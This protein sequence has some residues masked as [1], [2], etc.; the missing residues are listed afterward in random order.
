MVT[1]PGAE[2]YVDGEALGAADPEGRAGPFAVPAG[3]RVIRV[4][5]G[6]TRFERQQALEVDAD[7]RHETE[8]RARRGF[9]RLRVAPWARVRVNGKPMG[10]TPLPPISLFE[11]LHEIEL[12]NPVLGVRKTVSARVL[13][14]EEQLV[15]VVLARGS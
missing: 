6:E 5:H 11:G 4:V 15:E 3:A 13:A 1:E 12:E 10:L 8:V 9:V 7:G 2:V 14:G